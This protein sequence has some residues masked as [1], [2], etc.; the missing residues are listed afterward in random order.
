[1]QRAAL[2][3][4]LLLLLPAA[5]AVPGLVLVRDAEEGGCRDDSAFVVNESEGE[6]SYAYSHDGAYDAECDVETRRLLLAVREGDE[7][8]ASVEWHAWSKESISGP[9]RGSS[10]GTNDSWQFAW[11]DDVEYS[12]AWGDAVE[13]ALAGGVAAG[14]TRECAASESYDGAGSAEGAYGE[15]NAER[16]AESY[17][18][19]EETR[20]A[21]RVGAGAGG[22]EAAAG[23]RDGCASSGAGDHESEF[24]WNDT[25]YSDTFR[26]SGEGRSEC[27]RDDFFVSA[28]GVEASEGTRERCEASWSA[29]YHDTQEAANGPSSYEGWCTSAQGVRAAGAEVA[30]ESRST[31]RERCATPGGEVQCESVDE[32]D[33]YLVVRGIDSPAGPLFLEILLP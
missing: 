15:Q 27:A 29:D 11:D 2:G 14:R 18:Y 23:K 3:L 12:R 19:A 25:A 31:Y 21:E 28:A 1:M 4:A 32:T 8:L 20:C 9:S 5:S 22:H 30:L 13:V 10:S 6:D 24:A 17:A 33:D 16:A 7:D 26:G